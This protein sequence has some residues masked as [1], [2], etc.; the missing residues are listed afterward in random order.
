M[1]GGGISPTMSKREEMRIH[2]ELI[3]LTQQEGED[4]Y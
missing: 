3:V 2:E 1:F 4:F